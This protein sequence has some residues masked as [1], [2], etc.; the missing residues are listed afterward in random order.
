M[1]CG[2]YPDAWVE[3]GRSLQTTSRRKKM[4]KFEFLKTT[5]STVSLRRSGN[6]KCEGWEVSVK[7]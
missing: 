2:Y 1:V 4:R 6:D 5:C 3:Q 7:E